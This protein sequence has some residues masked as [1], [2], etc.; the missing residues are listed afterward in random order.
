MEVCPTHALIYVDR[1]KLEQ[2]SAEKNAVA[3]RWIP[4]HLCCS[5][6]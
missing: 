2:L 3:R 1:N 5:D 6:I 4:P